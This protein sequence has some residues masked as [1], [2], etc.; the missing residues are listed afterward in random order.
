MWQL[1]SFL[2][3]NLPLA[4]QSVKQNKFEVF[5]CHPT[6]YIFITISQWL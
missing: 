2:P 6:V 3:F 4:T 1:P 5:A